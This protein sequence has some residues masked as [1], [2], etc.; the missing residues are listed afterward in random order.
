MEIE[1]TSL[2]PPKTSRNQRYLQSVR[3]I[4]RW[5]YSVTSSRKGPLR[6]IEVL[7]GTNKGLLD[8]CTKVSVLFFIC[9]GVELSETL[10]THDGPRPVAPKNA[11][12]EIL[13]VHLVKVGLRSL[14]MCLSPSL[15]WEDG[16]PAK[17]PDCT[18]CHA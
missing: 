2:S 4:S 11:I 18:S 17:P 8:P 6:A 16:R 5:A 12:E 13:A 15:V 3:Q 14:Y 1:S 7:F 10:F 9:I